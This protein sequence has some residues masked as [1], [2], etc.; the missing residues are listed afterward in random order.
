MLE[1]S[2]KWFRI[3]YEQWNSYI[4]MLALSTNEEWQHSATIRKEIHTDKW[5]PSDIESE[6]IELDN[7]I[8]IN[9]EFKRTFS[10]EYEC[11]ITSLV[12]G[13]KIWVIEN[14]IYCI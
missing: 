3:I 5:I 11:K 6:Y 2:Q 10:Q 1:N 8:S 12:Q 13:I 7:S 4:Q 9:K 14:W